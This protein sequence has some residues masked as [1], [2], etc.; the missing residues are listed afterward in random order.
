[1]AEC[2]H[3]RFILSVEYPNDKGVVRA[4]NRELDMSLHASFLDPGGGGK[5]MNNKQGN[6]SLG[7]VMD[8]ASFPSL[9]EHMPSSS[10][11]S[12]HVIYTRPIL[13]FNVASPNSS[14]NGSAI[15][16]GNEQVGNAPINVVLASYLTTLRPTSSN[17]AHL[18]KL[19]VN[20]PNDADYDIW[21]PLASF[22]EVNDKI[23]Y[24]G[25]FFFK[26]SSTE[27]VDSVLRDG[28]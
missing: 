10:G 17:I 12:H 28:P 7:Y 23:R 25:S 20:V 14:L 13:Y 4:M 22:H 16:N 6:G 19:E 2:E 5:K 21:L 3:S 8:N 26:F 18:Q 15:E 24:M 9:H 27:G 11:G 1:R